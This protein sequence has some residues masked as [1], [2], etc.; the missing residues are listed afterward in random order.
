MSQTT[1]SAQSAARLT[2]SVCFT[3]TG[4]FIDACDVIFVT[5]PDDAI[6]PVWERLAQHGVAGRMFCHTSGSLASKVFSGAAER[7]AF[8]CSVH[9]MFAFTG[10]D[11]NT[12]GLE[13][14]C[15]T[16]EG[17][18]DRLDE[19][20][21][22][23]RRC[24]NRVLVINQK[25]KAL[26][27]LANVTVSNLVLALLSLGFDSFEKCGIERETA[28]AA[29]APLICNNVKNVLEQGFSQALTGPVE[30]NDE[31]TVLSHAD[32]LS[33]TLRI[34]YPLLSLRL[35]EL[36]KMKHP[37]RDYERLERLLHAI[38]RDINIEVESI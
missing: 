15:F 18:E 32:V 31:G 38:A 20:C 27:H 26:Y 14:A 12:A 1:A 6:G 21:G 16:A 10:R 24:N 33:G 22:I 5:V 4:A 28:M 25:D 34:V 23:F 13:D 11:G 37:G 19:V 30:R 17:D 2:D 36:A 35:C 8:A 7:G 29:A 9:P 3:D